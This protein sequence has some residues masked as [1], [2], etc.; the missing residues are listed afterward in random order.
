MK[1]IMLFES[2]SNQ[3]KEPEYE[4]VRFFGEDYV[5][6]KDAKKNRFDTFSDFAQHILRKNKIEFESKFNGSILYIKGKEDRIIEFL[7]NNS[8]FYCKA[9]GER[10]RG[11]R[12]LIEF[13]KT[14]VI[15]SKDVSGQNW[16]AWG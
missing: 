15:P 12:N 10:G 8:D 7:P 6:K 1:Y 16:S 3:R 13:I 9:T 2:W 4:T 14:G 11:L 5:I